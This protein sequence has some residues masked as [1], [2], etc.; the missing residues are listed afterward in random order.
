MSKTALG[1]TEYND[2]VL[3]L[4]LT[5]GRIVAP[6]DI[7]ETDDEIRAV[8]ASDRGFVAGNWCHQYIRQSADHNVKDLEEDSLR[9]RGDHDRWWNMPH[10]GG[11]RVDEP[12][13]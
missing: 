3:G 11:Q 2:F 8:L 6:E 10:L 12:G 5:L 4:E 7:G 13:R 1:P 9:L